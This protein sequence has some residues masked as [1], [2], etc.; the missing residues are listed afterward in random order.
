VIEKI[1]PLA[2]IEV[3][4]D[5]EVL[6]SK[7]TT[8]LCLRH[9]IIQL[10]VSLIEFPGIDIGHVSPP[11]KGARVV[12][13]FQNIL[14]GLLLRVVVPALGRAFFLRFAFL[15]REIGLGLVHL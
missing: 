15:L 11:I 6:R 12:I 3:P 14:H 13:V 5:I 10:A 2:L 4:R 1:I 9:Q 8:R 7:S